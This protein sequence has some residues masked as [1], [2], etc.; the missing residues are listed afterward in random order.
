M[1]KR[2]SVIK[3]KLRS[4]SLMWGI[5]DE[6]SFKD[7]LIKQKDTNIVELYG[8]Y[9]MRME[10]YPKCF[11]G[12]FGEL[13]EDWNYDQDV[14]K[15]YDTIINGIR[16]EEKSELR[17]TDNV[18]IEI[19]QG[20]SSD[21]KN[22]GKLRRGWIFDI[23]VDYVCFTFPFDHEYYILNKKQLEVLRAYCEGIW[24]DIVD[25]IGID[26]KRAKI[27]LCGI[28]DGYIKDMRRY[29]RGCNSVLLLLDKKM[30]NYNEVFRLT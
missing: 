9:K 27:G 21:G 10:L 16:I 28:E 8:G 19:L 13:E 29:D 17:V 18:D 6:D 15:S 12:L 14:D 30:Y 2:L 23:D 25:G 3:S 4:Y 20:Y 26:G 11:C 24:S 1:Y 22:S 7:H 5:K